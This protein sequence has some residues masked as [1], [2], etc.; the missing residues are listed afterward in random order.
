MEI[1]NVGFDSKLV[2]NYGGSCT[3]LGCIDGLL[4]RVHYSHDY[5]YEGESY[6]GG[7][8]IERIEC[9]ATGKDVIGIDFEDEL[10]MEALSEADQSHMQREAGYMPKGADD[11]TWSVQS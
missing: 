9:P 1:K 5:S 4:V 8:C 7:P 3:I 6:V 10:L 2:A 11:T